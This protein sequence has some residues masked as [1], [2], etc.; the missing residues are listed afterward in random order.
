MQESNFPCHIRFPY[1]SFAGMAI[2]NGLCDPEHMMK[3]GDYLYQI[4]LIDVNGRTVFHEMENL[5][6]KYIQE[7]KWNEAFDVSYK[8]K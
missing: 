5:A 6:M 2:G 7:R 1:V 4:G 8:H 3:Y